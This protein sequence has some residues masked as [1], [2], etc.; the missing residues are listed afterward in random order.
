MRGRPAE[1]SVNKAAGDGEGYG[2]R[3]PLAPRR[4]DRLSNWCGPGNIAQICPIPSVCTGEAVAVPLKP[5][6]GAAPNSPGARAAAGGSQAEA[7][8]R[9][10]QCE[11]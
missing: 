5:H 9:G 3:S 7:E 6:A 1:E 4:Q 8:A 10:R 2:R 11:H